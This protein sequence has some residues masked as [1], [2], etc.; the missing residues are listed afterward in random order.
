MTANPS[1]YEL[2]SRGDFIRR[3]VGPTEADVTRMLASL[4]LDSLEQ[5][6]ER[7]R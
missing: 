6:V 2:E 3:H 4:G 5:L 7:A 1:L